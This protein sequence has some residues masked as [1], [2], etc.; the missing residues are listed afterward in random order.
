MLTPSSGDHCQPQHVSASRQLVAG[1][2]MATGEPMWKTVLQAARLLGAESGRTFTRADLIATSRRIDRSHHEMAYNSVF[3]TM[4]IEAPTAATNRV[5]KVFHRIARG[6][7]VLIPV[8][9]RPRARGGQ[10]VTV[11][12]SPWRATGASH[13]PRS[14]VQSRVNALIAGFDGYVARFVADVPFQRAGQWE[15]HKATLTRRRELGSVAAS[16]RDERFLDLLYMT[17]QA[18]GI[19][20]RASRLVARDDFAKGLLGQEVTLTRLENL[21]IEESDIDAERVGAVLAAV[22]QDLGI[23]DNLSRIV[24]GSKA[25]HHLLPDLVPPLD[26]RWS[27]LFFRWQPSDPQINHEGI[28]VSAFNDFSA[29]ARATQPSRL[30]DAGW[31]TS[32]TK[33]L[34]NALIGYCQAELL[35]ANEIPVAQGN[36]VIEPDVP[37]VTPPIDDSPLP[38]RTRR[39]LGLRRAKP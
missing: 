15:Y 36:M 22:I 13:P 23:V 37:R 30:V 19:G 6:E 34:D 10:T 1:F 35:D 4:V 17:L 8:G 38:T 11:R 7:Y 14:H 28:F 9:E 18:W 16:L 25:V 5:G 32:S 31:N 21:S 12:R 3:Q 39:W 33:I 26:R 24:P 29:I 27:G 20:R 2:V